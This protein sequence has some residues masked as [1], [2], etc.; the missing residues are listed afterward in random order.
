MPI[1]FQEVSRVKRPGK[2]TSEEVR[3]Q[4]KEAV[5]QM[6]LSRRFVDMGGQLRQELDQAG[7]PDKILVL[8]VDGSF[9][10]RTCFGEIAERTVLL[11]RARKNAKL[12]FARWTIRAASQVRQDNNR[13]WK[14]TKIFYG[15]K[16]R[17]ARY[18]AGR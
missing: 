13:A 11:A 8:T 10:N 18:E 3:K 4:Y 16:R 14:T 6:N 15:G 1:R 17:K 9:R 7:G 12:C 5:Q 2:K